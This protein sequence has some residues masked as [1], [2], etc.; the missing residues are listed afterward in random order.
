MTFDSF[1]SYDYDEIDYTL[2]KKSNEKYS[3][4]S[5]YGTELYMLFTYFRKSL[6]LHLFLY[7]KIENLKVKDL[8]DVQISGSD[9]GQRKYESTELTNDGEK[10]T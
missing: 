9:I 3:L 5:G 7:A 6:L 8:S 1:R 10:S 4:A 2:I